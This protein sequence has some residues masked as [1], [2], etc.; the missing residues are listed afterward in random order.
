M[1][2]SL[3]NEEKAKKNILLA[4]KHLTSIVTLSALINI[5]SI[6]VFSLS[7]SAYKLSSLIIKIIIF[8]GALLINIVLL[9]LYKKHMKNIALMANLLYT[10]NPKKIPKIFFSPT[11][12]F[13]YLTNIFFLAHTLVKFKN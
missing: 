3:I 13:G 4:T 7:F 9:I 8:G 5:T 11:S 2:E 10:Q 12:A 6:L 1:K